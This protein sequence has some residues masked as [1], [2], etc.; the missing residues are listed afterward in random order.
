VPQ[1]LGQFDR[2]TV[3]RALGISEKL[4]A[5]RAILSGD[6]SEAHLQTVGDDWAFEEEAGA[7][8]AAWGLEVELTRPMASLSG[9]QK[10]KVFLAGVTLHNPGLILLDEPT[11][12]LDLAGRERLG[13]LVRSHPG[14]VILVSH[15]IAL[16]NLVDMIYEITAE[17]LRGYGGN[18]TFY[19][20]QK[21]TE[22]DALQRD[23]RGKEADLRKAREKQREITERKQ[24][25]DA[26]GK[27]KQTKAGVAR[28]MM[29][30]L[31]N[32]AE[33]SSSRIKDMHA[34]KLSGLK[35]SLIRMK[36]SLDDAGAIRFSFDDSVLHRG[37]MLFRA[38]Q[39]N[40]DY[41]G[42]SLWK[43]NLDLEI[44]SGERI[45][46]Q[47]M[48]GSGKSTLLRII[49]G[50]VVPKTGTVQAG[51]TRARYIDQDYSLI[52]AECSVFDQACTFNH[53]GLRDHEVKT[54][55]MR[56]LFAQND[57]DK[58]CAAL[59]GGEKMRLALLCVTIAGGAPE[60][61]LLDE[62]TNNLDIRH[63]EILADAVG[64]YRG[65]L[66]MVS[67]DKHFISRSGIS[68]TIS[69]GGGAP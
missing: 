69:L 8:L 20:V 1:I 38:R 2:M 39:I 66:V 60:M 54:R 22:Q 52:R 24:K 68:R 61:L 49:L 23:I 11:N 14:T 6:A 17:G 59:S 51:F 37:K 67:H 43:E 29:N 65:T 36:G 32:N 62:P 55:L 25:L 3:A 41:G 30:T 64:E 7:A 48:N 26:R 53:S 10:T 12:H 56:F 13:E 44:T 18:Y 27:K 50:E 47:G 42:G 9:G 63:L 57:W 19:A 15:D 5:L 45:A 33:K 46:L 28:I 21:Q 35:D 34:E 58:P 4:Q 40:H 31:R 16:L